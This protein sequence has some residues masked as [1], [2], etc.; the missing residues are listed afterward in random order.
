MLSKHLDMSPSITHVIGLNLSLMY[1]MAEWQDLSG[2]NPWDVSKNVG[3]NIACRIIRAASWTI[4]SLGE[5]IVR[6][7]VPPLGLGIRILR[8]G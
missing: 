4:L 1:L 2:R 8:C 3:S 7:R 5:A 6:G